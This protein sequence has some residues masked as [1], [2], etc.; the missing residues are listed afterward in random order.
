VFFTDN[1]GTDGI[2]KEVNP[3]TG[4]VTTIATVPALFD[5][6]LHR[7]IDAIQVTP[8]YIFGE[9]GGYESKSIFRIPRAGGSAQT[10]ASP[11]GGSLM[12]KIGGNVYYMSGFSAIHSVPEA[13]GSSAFVVNGGFK[14][15][16]AVDEAAGVIYY[17]D[18]HT[19]NVRRFDPVTATVP[20]V[21]TGLSA[22]PYL[23]VDANNLYVTAA[24]NLIAVNKSSGIATT[25]VGDGTAVQG[26]SDGLNLYY[27]DN[28]SEQIKRQPLAGG[29]TQTLVDAPGLIDMAV[30]NGTVYWS[31]GGGELGPGS[32]WTVPEPGSAAF[33]LVAASG[34]VIRRRR[35]RA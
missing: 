22:E 33:I 29:L 27:F 10:L 24:G 16:H 18:Y 6:G 3:S 17:S 28:V 26:Q 12:G 19:R 31:T 30:G 21:L 7:G 13:G 20:D 35:T 2:L 11:S 15:S 34:A 23:S 8:S 4:Q 9:T 14:R 1:A 25:L 5:A 32:I